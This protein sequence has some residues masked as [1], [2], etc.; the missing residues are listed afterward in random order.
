MT[1]SSSLIKRFITAYKC[2]N[3]SSSG[4]SIG[5][6]G[7]DACHFKGLYNHLS[8]D[9]L[10]PEVVGHIPREISRFLWYF[11]NY[12]GK[13]DAKVHS[14]RHRRSP[15]PSGGLEIILVAKFA[16]SDEKRRY[17]AHLSTLIQWNYKV[18]E[19]VMDQKNG[20]ENEDDIGLFDEEDIIILETDESDLVKCSYKNT[21]S[22]HS[23]T[24]ST[25]SFPLCGILHVFFL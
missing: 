2:L 15:I 16:M 22:Y 3:E 23:V 5:G 24:L 1:L 4:T 21:I 20:Q 18:N 12:G 9:K 19:E 10:I 11:L 6:N 25:F 8:S 14:E 7:N 13:V 17:L